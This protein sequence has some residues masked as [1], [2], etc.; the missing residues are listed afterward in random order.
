MKLCLKFVICI[1]IC[2]LLLS[3]VSAF[4]VATLYNGNYPLRM[5]AGEEKDTFF[6]V[7]NVVK[8]DDDVIISPELNKGREVAVL[9]EGIKDYDLPFG[10]E[11]EVPVRIKVPSD[12][13]VGKRY[14]IGAVFKPS[15]K[16]KGGGNIQFV[17]NIGKSFPVVVVGDN[18]RLPYEEEEFSLTL[19][20]ESGLGE[21]MAPFLGK[22]ISVWVVIGLGLLVFVIILLIVVIVVIRRRKVIIQ[23]VVLR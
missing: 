22:E 12:A 2:F 8:G 21:T 7:R 1:F 4:S 18:G 19:E 6:L 13:E 3:S 20:D 15:V 14:E 16:T 17:V 23:Q 10:D 5:K 9:I 11:A